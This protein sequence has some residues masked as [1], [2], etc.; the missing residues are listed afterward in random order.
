MPI[1]CH[2]NV[3]SLTNTG[4][5]CHFFHNFHEKPPVIMP[6]FGQKSVN[7]AETRL[8]YGPKKSIWCT[9]FSWLH[10]ANITLILLN[11]HRFFAYIHK[12][13]SAISKLRCSHVNC[14][15]IFMKIPQRLCIYL[16]LQTR[17]L[18]KLH[19]IMGKKVN[20]MPFFRFLTKKLLLILSTRRPFSKKD[21]DLHI[22]CQ[23]NVHSLK[24]TVLS[25]HF[26]NFS[27]TSS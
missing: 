10:F 6:I 15:K 5:W 25:C 7:S 11:P 14:F 27:L 24:N 23:K 3:H 4:L 2:K 17:F 8:Y 12:N 13:T 20:R 21:T 9:I 22:F 19:Y 26:F 16:F 18:S 1:F